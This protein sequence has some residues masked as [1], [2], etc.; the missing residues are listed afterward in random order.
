MSLYRLSKSLPDLTMED[1]VETAEELL[2]KGHFELEWARVTRN[3][4]PFLTEATGVDAQ[5]ASRLL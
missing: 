1:I 2:P 4:E 3:V 5:F